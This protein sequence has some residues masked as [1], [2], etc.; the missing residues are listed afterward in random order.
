MFTKSFTSYSSFIHSLSFN[1]VSVKD[2]R[3]QFDDQRFGKHSQVP[4]EIN[5]GKAAALIKTFEAEA[6]A[7][8]SLH[9]FQRKKYDPGKKSGM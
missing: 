5:V 3:A 7:S 6:V 4:T 1:T 2:L 8:E 9:E